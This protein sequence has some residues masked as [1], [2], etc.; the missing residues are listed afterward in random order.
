MKFGIFPPDIH[1]YVELQASTGLFNKHINVQ[2]AKV[3]WERAFIYST[4]S[5]HKWCT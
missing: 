1:S 4:V 3:V 2:G 5:E